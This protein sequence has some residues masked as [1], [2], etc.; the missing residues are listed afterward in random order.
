MGQVGFVTPHSH[1][2]ITLKLH[3][4][5]VLRTEYI[6]PVPMQRCIGKLSF[7]IIAITYANS[8]C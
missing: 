3:A 4:Y 1:S 7:D 5:G 2:C 8:K 6:V